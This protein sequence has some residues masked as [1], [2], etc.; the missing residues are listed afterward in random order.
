MTRK[1]NA[2]RRHVPQREVDSRDASLPAGNTKI[3]LEGDSRKAIEHLDIVTA[4][5]PTAMHFAEE[6]AFM[7]ENVTIMVHESEDPNAEN[8][9]MVSVNGRNQYIFRGQEITVRRCY[10]ERL[11][12]AKRQAYKQDLTQT[13][14]VLYNSMKKSTALMYPFSLIE[15]RNPVGRDWLRKVMAEI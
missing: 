6:L 12:R 3:N 10:V 2:A 11:A 8:P 1:S 14:P 5:G 9:I 15:D 4:D 13:D 7:N